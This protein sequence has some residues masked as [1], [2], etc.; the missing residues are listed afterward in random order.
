MSPLF[1]A[2]A[3]ARTAHRH[4]QTARELEA[5]W[6]E[7]APE[8]QAAVRVELGAMRQAA[9]DVRF[10]LTHGVRGFAQEF[11]AARDGVEA[12]PIDPGKPFGE[13]VK[14]LGRATRAMATAL[15]APPAP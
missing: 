10:K 6:D 15:Q 8:Q 13:S 14:D 9:G 3:L 11:K 4:L 1:A 5:R 7:L 12:A 2:A